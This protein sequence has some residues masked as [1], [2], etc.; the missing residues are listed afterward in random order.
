MSGI[1][2]TKRAAGDYAAETADRQL[3]EVC[4]MED[5][6]WVALRDSSMIEN[7]ETQ[8]HGFKTMK[9]AQAAAMEAAERAAY[10]DDCAAA[11]G[12][13]RRGEPEP[14][15]VEAEPVCRD[16]GEYDARLA[17]ECCRGGIEDNAAGPAENLFTPAAELSARIRAEAEPVE[18]VR[19]ESRQVRR[20]RERRER[21]AATRPGP[22]DGG[23]AR[24]LS[25]AATGER[26][27]EDGRRKYA[28]LR[29]SAVQRSRT[30]P[31]PFDSAARCL[32]LARAWEADPDR[33]PVYTSES[34]W[35]AGARALPNPVFSAYGEARVRWV[36]KPENMGLRLVGLAHEV[37]PAGYAY[38][39]N[40]VEH[41]GRYLDP[42]GCETV[43]GV[44]YRLPGRDGRARYL[45]GYADPWNADRDGNG[46]ALLSLEIIAGEPRDS[47]WE[48]D[49]ALRDAARAADRI[50]ERMAEAERDY[51]ESRRV[52]S[53][54]RETA[55]ESMESGRAMVAACRDLRAAIATRR[56]SPA[57]PAPF[58]R[59]Y[60][61][62]AI[63]ALRV[64]R[65]EYESA[66]EAFLDAIGEAPARP[67]KCRESRRAA[68]S[69][70][71]DGY[72]EAC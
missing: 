10:L 66:R 1:V 61:R 12:W 36:E 45:A 33:K 26:L 13:P 49:S 11:I 35:G 63:A 56:G 21:K 17:E 53:E 40:A 52:G 39:R 20:A 67:G 46:P 57:F 58:A 72:G 47:D 29:R 55:R 54:A 71:W 50:A 2:W 51:Q 5:G 22:Y 23:R 32:D 41:S 25:A 28:A 4:K 69:A 3:L 38:S 24:S 44:V 48:A 9:A 68:A 19:R 43:A 34:I 8:R 59:E 65:T 27:T 30:F 70:F 16:C 31:A 42:D 37:S 18:T 14:E 15:P 7:P 6:A 64:A 62:E 60:V